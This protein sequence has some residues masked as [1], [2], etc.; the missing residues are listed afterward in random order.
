M[1][2][3]FLSKGSLSARKGKKELERETGWHGWDATTA[4][5]QPISVAFIRRMLLGLI[6]F[7]TVIFA[8]FNMSLGSPGKVRQ[9]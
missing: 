7:F 9:I 3:V 8:T 4:A 1:S 5:L 2:S 6:V